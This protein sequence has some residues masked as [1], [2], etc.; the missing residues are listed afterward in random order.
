MDLTYDNKT[1]EV[2]LYG[3]GGS[4]HG[5]T[6][7]SFL[8]DKSVSLSWGTKGVYFT[9]SILLNDFKLERYLWF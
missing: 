4:N 2:P 3:K 9:L 8:D 7:N 5:I 6:K 1:I